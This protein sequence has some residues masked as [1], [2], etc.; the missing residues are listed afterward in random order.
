MKVS[1][2]SYHIRSWRDRFPPYAALAAFLFGLLPFLLA[3]VAALG[4]PA[5]SRTILTGPPPGPCAGATDGAE[6]I[7][8]TDVYGYPVAPAAARG[9]AHVRL[10]SETVYPVRRNGRRDRGTEVKVH[11]D[12]LANIL[13]APDAC[14]E[15]R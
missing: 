6:Y 12:G 5:S 3:S 2:D 15:R 11:V 10:G 9:V 8:G 14:A 13:A 1:Y 4:A 7:G